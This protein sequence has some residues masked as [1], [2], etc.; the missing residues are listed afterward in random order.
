MCIRDRLWAVAAV[1]NSAIGNITALIPFNIVQISHFN[2]LGRRLPRARGLG[3][4]G[5]QAALVVPHRGAVLQQ[6]VGEMFRARNISAVFQPS[7]QTALKRR[8]NVWA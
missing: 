4:F 2:M 6:D 7:L 1:A 3:K 8:I 5:V